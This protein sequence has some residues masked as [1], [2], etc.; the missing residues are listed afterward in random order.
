MRPLVQFIRRRKNW[1][2]GG[3][4]F[5]GVIGI[6]LSYTPG[7]SAAR[8]SP[9]EHETVL[10][11]FA[12]NLGETALCDRI[13]WTAYQ[14][15]SVLFGG[16]GASFWRSACYERVAQARHD[17]SI[18]WHVR[19]LVDFD[20]LSSGYS[21]LSCLRRTKSRYSSGIALP[22]DLLIRTF[23]QLGYDIDQLQ[24][25]GVIPP[26]IR[27]RD[28]YLSLERDAAVLARAHQLLTQLDPSLRADDRSY[29][30]QLAAVGT[31]NPDLCAYIPSD[32]RINQVQAPFRDW[33]FYTVAVDT[34]DVRIC[35]RMTPA[36]GEAKVLA[37]QA[38]GVRPEIAEQMG[39]HVECSRIGAHLGPRPHYGP[40]VPS[41]EEQT[42]RLF[43]ALGI[44]MPSAHDWSASEIAAFYQ[45]FLFALW[46]RDEPN[47][48]RDAARA[49]LVRRLLALP[50][51]S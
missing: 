50:G 4:A 28:V 6:G 8:R 30:A 36:A 24:L 26:A 20:P 22:N 7:F 18:C 40:E 19:P 49:K 13:S 23:K 41:D 43:T 27:V 44:A 2:L 38:A 12:Q 32:Q 51:D 1:L 33:C 9:T 5:V 16:G 47:S 34:Q 10:Y 35:D 14:S 37:A 17:P 31:A 3:I 11:Y 25:E 21:A 48:A 39:L 15:Y 29:L 45:Q 46:P 42:Q